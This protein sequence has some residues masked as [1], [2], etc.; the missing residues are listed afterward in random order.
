[1]AL[2]ICLFFDRRG[3]LL[4]RELWARLE[5]QG[6]RTLQTHTHGHHH[7]HLS[8]AVL[9]DWDLDRVSDA[10]RDLPDAGPFE[11]TF[12][13]TLAFPRG[14]AA[15][16]PSIPAGVARRQER[17]TQALAGTGATLHRHYLPGMWVPHVSLG[18]GVNGTTLPD[19]AKAISDVLPLAVTIDRAA[20]V[21]S[22]NGQVWPLPNIP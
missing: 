4:M 20:I 21:D 8:Y 11:L 2:A 3:D 7:P 6:I 15:L 17:V 22:S 14:R 1:M 13:G 16:A 9:L 12:H 5:D 10:M 19:V 18:H